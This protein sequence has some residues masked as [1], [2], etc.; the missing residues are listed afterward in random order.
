MLV[1]QEP[2]SFGFQRLV[3]QAQTYPD[4]GFFVQQQGIPEFLAETGDRRR[5]YLILYYLKP[6]QAYACRTIPQ[7]TGAVEFAGPYPITDGEYRMLDDF[8]RG[9]FR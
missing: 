4:L 5:Q 2:P 7:H 1:R 3:M 8:R 6:R 9:R